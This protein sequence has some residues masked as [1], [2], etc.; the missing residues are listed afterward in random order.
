MALEKHVVELTAKDSLSRALQNV[1]KEATNASKAAEQ[2]AKRAARSTE[3]WGKAAKAIGVG[4]GALTGIAI[5]LAN[6]SEVVN[7]RLKQSVENAGDSYDE[8]KDQID[9]AAEAALN[10]AFDDEDALAALAKLTDATGDTEEAIKALAIAQDVARGRGIS[11]GAATDLVTKASLGQYGMLKRVGIVIDDNATKEEALAAIQT[12]Y[13]GQAEAYADTNAA[14]WDKIGNTIENKLEGIGGAL[15]DFQ[16][17]L[18]AIGAAATTIGPLGDAFTALGGKAKLASLAVSAGPWAGLALGVGLAAGAIYY[19]TTRES[20]AEKATRALNQAA[21][22]YTQTIIDQTTA[23]ANLGLLDEAKSMKAYLDVINTDG[24]IAQKRIDVLSQAIEEIPGGGVN[25]EGLGILLGDLDQAQKDWIVSILDS[26]NYL[27]DQ[28]ITAAELSAILPTLASGF[29]LTAGQ[30]AEL[31]NAMIDVTK[32]MANPDLFGGEIGTKAAQILADM[33]NEVIGV[34]EAITQLLALPLDE[35]FNKAARAAEAAGGE[36]AGVTKELIKQAS[37]NSRAGFDKMTEGALKFQEQVDATAV[38]SKQLSADLDALAI[39]LEFD[40]ANAASAAYDRVVGFTSGMVGAINTSKEWADALIAPVGVMS[41]L[42]TMLANG[43]IDIEDYNEA[44]QA[45]IDITDASARATAAMN[46]I[47]IK[48]ADTVADGAEA[49]ADYLE[50]IAALDEAEQALALAWADSDLAGRANDIAGMATEFGNMDG[51]QQAAFENM[52]LSAA[53]TDPALAGVLEDLGLIKVDLDDPTGWALSIDESS[54]TASL[55]D[56]VDAIRD[57]IDIIADIP[58]ATVDVNA[59]TEPYFRG[60]N[61]I[62]EDAGDSFVDVWER[63]HGFGPHALGGMMPY[64]ETAALGRVSGG[65]MAL[66]GEHGPEVVRL[67]GGDMVIPNHASRYM[68]TGRGGGGI[69]FNG[70]ITI[71]ANNPEHFMQQMRSYTNTMERR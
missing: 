36:I 13:A 1:G 3:D 23:L 71:V 42:D 15:A 18:L 2:G 20:D 55:Q 53:A 43:I 35:E 31:D 45:Q 38:A 8:L 4:L 22:D 49:T 59:N 40:A 47:Q 54:A 25:L 9:A 14:A 19:L 61:D 39:S 69:T 33:K 30:A 5:K 70:P 48:Q 65:N 10:L 11:L 37:V 28:T 32:A 21:A 26:N 6:E 27:N 58:D 62:P 57:L 67:H 41:E 66:V 64:A 60:I 17:P 46:K 50:N 56:V 68:D 44:Q 7:E 52:V 16:M 51:A 29:E 24:L 34:D 12:K 63:W